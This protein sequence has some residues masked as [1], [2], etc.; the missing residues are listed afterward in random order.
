MRILG[1]VLLIITCIALGVGAD[2]FGE[3][4]VS[5]VSAYEHRTGGVYDK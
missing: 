4:E 3:A 5:L 1:T 2:Y